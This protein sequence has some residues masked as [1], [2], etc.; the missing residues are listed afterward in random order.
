V[1]LR[2]LDGISRRIGASISCVRSGP[3]V[4]DAVI[5]VFTELD[6]S[7]RTRAAGADDKG[8]TERESYLRGVL[9]SYD[10]MSNIM[11]DAERIN[12]TSRE[13]RV[14]R[15]QLSAFAENVRHTCDLMMVFALSKG[16]SSA[17]T[18]LVDINAIAES[19]LARKKT[20][21]A[22]NVIVNLGTGIPSVKTVGK[23]FEMGLE[24]LIRGCMEQSPNGI[25][26]ETGL[27]REAGTGVAGV[28][29][30]ERGV[31]KPIVEIGESLR[32]FAADNSLRREAGLLLLKSLPS[33]SHR[34][35]VERAGDSFCFSA[36][37]LM[38]IKRKVGPGAQSEE[39]S[40][41]GHDED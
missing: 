40:E 41:R 29:I 32:E 33:E 2:T 16:A 4:V 37:I 34:I 6:A 26:I 39:S 31:T 23:V 25:E 3:S 7:G 15:A 28:I 1:A 11:M 9:D 22:Q 38:P 24:M 19:V 17:L 20:A 8:E 35:K 30:R 27:W 13:G 21:A 12:S 5:V 18:E 36:G 14:S 10:L